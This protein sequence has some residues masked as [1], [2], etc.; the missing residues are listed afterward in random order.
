MAAGDR[1]AFVTFH[2]SAVLRA[3]DEAA[4]IRAALVDD[5]RAAAAA[6]G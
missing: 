4:E 3:A 5:L 2:P 6:T 1:T